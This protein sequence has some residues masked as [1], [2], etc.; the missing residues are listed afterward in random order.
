MQ[1][2][3]NIHTYIHAYI[4][5]YTHTH[6]HTHIH[7]YTHTHIY[8]GTVGTYILVCLFTLFLDLSTPLCCCS[9]STSPPHTSLPSSRFVPDQS[10]NVTCVWALLWRRPEPSDREDGPRELGLRGAENC[11]R[12]CH[13]EPSSLTPLTL[14]QFLF[15]QAFSVNLAEERKIDTFYYAI[16]LCT[17]GFNLGISVII[18]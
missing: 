2:H 6:I 7:T 4:H 13:F 3:T 8:T 16:F 18:I 12:H 17:E 9:C 14:C 10:Q 15:R 5:T 1:T 11:G